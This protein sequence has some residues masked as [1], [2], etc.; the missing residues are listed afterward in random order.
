LVKLN[1]LLDD[2]SRILNTHT[3]ISIFPLENKYNCD[4]REGE[5]NDLDWIVENGEVNEIIADSILEYF[6]FNQIGGILQNWIKKLSLTGSLIIVGCDI[7]QLARLITFEEIDNKIAYT[8]I[9]GEQTANW[10]TKKSCC[11]MN[12]MIMALQAM[13]L[14]VVRKEYDNY[15]YVIEAKRI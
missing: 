6:P 9:Y 4:L 8:E 10:K 3:N 15:K 11:S 1:L 7:K 12:E 5:I 2:S 14:K 13:G